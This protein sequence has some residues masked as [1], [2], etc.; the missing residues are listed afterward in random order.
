M[1]VFPARIEPLEQNY[2]L[3]LPSRLFKKQYI[4][5]SIENAAVRYAVQNLEKEQYDRE[6]ETAIKTILDYAE[7]SRIQRLIEHLRKY[8]YDMGKKRTSDRN[9][10]KQDYKR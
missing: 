3:P 8:S 5:R 7:D 1:E 6:I 9:V 10:G 2:P 4:N